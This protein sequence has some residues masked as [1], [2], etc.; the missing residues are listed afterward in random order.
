LIRERR[1]SASAKRPGRQRLSSAKGEDIIRVDN[2]IFR[3]LVVLVDAR[4]F[5]SEEALLRG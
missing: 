2:V 3:L 5:I 4:A 1:L